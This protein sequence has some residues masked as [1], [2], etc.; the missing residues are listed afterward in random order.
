MRHEI[1]ISGPAFGLRPIE[2]E[3]AEFM[4]ALRNAENNLYLHPTSPDPEDQRRYIR[5]Y[6]ERPGD[7][8]FIIER[9]SD[10]RS[11]GI[12]AIYD[13]ESEAR[14]GEW[15][16]WIL[17]E[18]SMAAVET[19]LLVYRVGFGKL[20]IETLRT[21][22]PRENES[23]LAFHASCGAKE[24]ARHTR[25]FNFGERIYD[26][27]EQHMTRDQWRENEPG[28]LTQAEQVARFLSRSRRETRRRA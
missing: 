5:R 22:T 4:A 15:G 19:A 25:H 7:Y 27:V 26:A 18:G 9:S 1:R 11:E 21:M 10:G 16:R 3:D 17:S 13:V 20:G 14:T 2:L 8:Y 12:V 24:I 28:V 23:V 6:F